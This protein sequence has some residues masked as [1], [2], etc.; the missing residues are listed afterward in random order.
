MKKSRLLALFAF[1]VFCT[2]AAPVA[3]ADTIQ[4][5]SGYYAVFRASGMVQHQAAFGG[6]NFGAS[7]GGFGI[8]RL[9]GCDFCSPSSVVSPDMGNFLIEPPS[10]HT[11]G[12][13]T[14]TRRRQRSMILLTTSACGF[15]S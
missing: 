8:S 6:Q 1:V 2:L 3:Q 5:T 11:T 13:L 7:G 10:S 14:L 9:P 12:L 15:N 4:I